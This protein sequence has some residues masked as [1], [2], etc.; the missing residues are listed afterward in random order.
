MLRDEDKYL[1]SPSQY[2]DQNIDQF[3]SSLLV[4]PSS[5]PIWIPPTTAQV[6]IASTSAAEGQDVILRI[7]HSPPD[8]LV[9]MWF[10][11]IEMKNSNLIGYILMPLNQ[12]IA[13]PKYSG[14]ETANLE[15]SLIIR[16]VT[17]SDLGLYMVVAVLTNLQNAT[18]FAWLSVYRE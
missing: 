6:S 10:K 7:R 4:F 8:V 18:G 12:Y 17:P 14:R 9:Y 1:T 16:K 15:G 3:L 13:G 5:L 11:G 2:I